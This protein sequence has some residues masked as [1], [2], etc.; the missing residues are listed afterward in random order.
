MGDVESE[1][2]TVAVEEGGGHEGSPVY[3]LVWEVGRPALGCSGDSLGIDE[4]QHQN[5]ERV[6]ALNFI[7]LSFPNILSC[8]TISHEP[9]RLS[10]DAM[11][12]SP[13]SFT[14]HPS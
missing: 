9:S 11:S 2:Q 12:D 7:L 6:S 1:E 3:E 5:E 14:F 10:R 13:P 8:I 4:L